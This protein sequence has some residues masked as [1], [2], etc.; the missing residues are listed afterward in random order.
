MDESTVNV[1][2]LFNDDDLEQAA[3]NLPLP[4]NDVV[5]SAAHNISLECKI[6]L[7]ELHRNGCR[8]RVSWSRLGCV[9][10]ISSDSTSIGIQCLRLKKQTATWELSSTYTL[11]FAADEAPR[12]WTHLCWSST[13]IDLAIFD[14]IGWVS[15]FAMSTA[16]AVNRFQN[17]NFPNPD[18]GDELKQAV[19]T[20]WLPAADRESPAVPQVSKQGEHWAHII[21][22]RKPIGPIWPRALLFVTRLGVLRL[23]YMRLDRTWSE[24]ETTLS[25]FSKAN[26]LLTHAAFAP[27]LDGSIIVTTHSSSGKYS[28]Y[29]VQVLR[30]QNQA[31][32]IVTTPII[33]DVE[34]IKSDIHNQ[35]LSNNNMNG[36][37]M[38]ESSSSTG[39]IASLSHLEIV[40]TTD[41]EKAVQIPPTIFAINTIFSS[42][43]GIHN[44][45]EARHSTIQRW[46]LHTVSENLHSRF[47]E[48]PTKGITTSSYL[49]PKIIKTVQRLPTISFDGIITSVHLVDFSTALAITT[50]DGTTTFYVSALFFSCLPLWWLPVHVL[51]YRAPSLSMY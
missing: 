45:L 46:S 6:R 10:S 19:G 1:D 4:G 18:H 11:D 5:D 50:A 12:S 49:A 14:T 20:Y 39:K 32:Q 13:G 36:D 25:T 51:Y 8:Q 42:L 41:I 38:N 29:S 23:V 44:S 31:D 22:K 33:L 48:V 21:T 47:D 17:L 7:D 28:V 30:P 2:D 43:P 24:T 15:I 3:L 35:I 27:A 37:L 34:H 9:A 26:D 16:S 40:P